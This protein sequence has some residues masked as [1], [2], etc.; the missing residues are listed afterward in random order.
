MHPCE[1]SPT[2]SKL[3]KLSNEKTFHIWIFLSA[4]N[5]CNFQHISLFL[6]ALPPQ[7]V[8]TRIP[9]HHNPKSR[10]SLLVRIKIAI[11]CMQNIYLPDR[12]W[13]ELK[14]LRAKEIEIPSWVSRSIYWLK[15]NSRRISMRIWMDEKEIGVLTFD[16]I[17]SQLALPI[18]TASRAIHGLFVRDACVVHAEYWAF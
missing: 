4:Y 7:K 12:A 18:Y 5:T 6:N 8:A 17:P 1:F 10:M 16:S 14:R 9:Q 11:L 2:I 3:S 15:R 13:D